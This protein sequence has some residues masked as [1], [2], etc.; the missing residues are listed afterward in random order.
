MALYEEIK[1]SELESELP[2]KRDESELTSEKE[3]SEEYNYV[4]FVPTQ[5]NHIRLSS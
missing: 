2:D 4:T 3:M 1:D 5:G